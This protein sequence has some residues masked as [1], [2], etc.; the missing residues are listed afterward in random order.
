[1]S[2]VSILHSSS[3]LCELVFFWLIMSGLG[4]TCLLLLLGGW[5]VCNDLDL[6]FIKA[7]SHW[8]FKII[9]IS[10]VSC[11]IFSHRL[12]YL[13]SISL[14]R[15]SLSISIPCYGH[16]DSPFQYS[17]LECEV[18]TL[19]RSQSNTPSLWISLS[20]SPIHC[21]PLVNIESHSS[22]NSLTTSS[23]SSLRSLD[24]S[25]LL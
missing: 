17:R 22:L 2:A 7:S 23:I 10:W 12:R 1:M 19:I 18:L 5:G 11:F 16:I 3:R 13:S 21:A 8:F 15:F 14:A 4:W 24:Q 6:I 20:S 25:P 9:Q